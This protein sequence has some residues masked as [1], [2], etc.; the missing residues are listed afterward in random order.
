MNCCGNHQNHN[1]DQEGAQSKKHK[2]H[3]WMMILCC[4][5]PIVLVAM[6]LFSGKASGFSGNGLLFLLV[7]ICPLSH[8]LI[9]PLMMR[10]TKKQ[11]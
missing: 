4:I 9:M 11:S 1:H 6:L 2:I 10:K 3:N 7:L 8:M 5:V